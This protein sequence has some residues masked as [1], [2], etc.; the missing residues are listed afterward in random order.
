MLGVGP[1][2]LGLCCPACLSGIHLCLTL[3]HAAVPEEKIALAIAPMITVIVSRS[4][5]RQLAW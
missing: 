2:L 1:P 5:L 4:N 3:F